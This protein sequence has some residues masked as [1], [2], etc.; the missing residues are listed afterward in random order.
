MM[1]TSDFIKNILVPL[2]SVGTAV[3]VGVLNFKVSENDLELRKRDQV[4]EQRLSDINLVIQKSREQ[5]EERESN[6]DFN[7][8]IYDI[9]TQSLEEGNSQ[10]QQAARAFV[11]VMV[12]EPLRSSLLNVLKQGGSQN[13][14]NEISKILLAEQKF[15]NVT[16]W[17]PKKE[18]EAESSYNWGNWDF[19]I[20]WCA[21][22]GER[23]KL[24]AQAIAKQLKAEDA[25]GRI[26]VRELPNSINAKSSYQIDGY[27]IRRNTKDT[28]IATALKRLSE[29][30]LKQTLDINF[31]I[32]T[33][34][35]KIP[36]Y[37]S[38]FVCPPS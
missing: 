8:R 11:V 37:I 9:V 20:F 15:Q 30:T 7:L 12:D 21:S 33:N 22:S 28:K 25:E 36:K 27:E 35:Q 14:K 17:A 1:S 3:M 34:K 13:T 2:I 31:S 26:R 16:Y 38:A 23:A 19:D 24:H 4:L 10:K 6:Q 18:R 32:T 29:S 5:R